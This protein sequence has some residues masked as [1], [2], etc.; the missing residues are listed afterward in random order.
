MIFKE[1]LVEKL[2][3]KQINQLILTKR[4]KNFANS[5]EKDGLNQ[6]L[7]FTGIQGTGKTSLAKILASKYDNLILNISDENGIDT[8]R[9]KITDFCQNRSIDQTTEIKVIVLEE[10]DAASPKFWSSI[11]NVI[12]TYSKYT[13]FIGTANYEHKIPPEIKSRLIPIKFDPIDDNEKNE[14]KEQWQNTL[15]VIL[16]KFGIKYDDITLNHLIDEN[17]PDFRRTLNKIQELKNSGV[18]DLTSLIK[19]TELDESLFE[20]YKLIIFGNNDT[21]KNYQ[22][23]VSRYSKMSEEVLSKLGEQFISYILKNHPDKGYL[24]NK[25]LIKIAEYQYKHSFSLDKVVNLVALIF[26]LSTIFKTDK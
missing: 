7:L 6:N 18:T 1:L 26:E 2:R 4:I 16:S 13:R 8:V 17:F 25:L 15:K 21:V 24:I 23:I 12:E 22:F 20:L 5:L 14:L 9:T 11:R 10:C 19:S 3:P